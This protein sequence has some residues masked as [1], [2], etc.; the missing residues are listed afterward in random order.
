MDYFAMINLCFSVTVV[1]ML[2]YSN[3]IQDV[4]FRPGSLCYWSEYLNLLQ[5]I[6]IQ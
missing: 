1:N 6:R 5:Y 3:Y 4:R 2:K